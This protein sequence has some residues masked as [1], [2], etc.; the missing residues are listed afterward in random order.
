[1]LQTE[2]FPAS[3]GSARVTVTEATCQYFHSC[4]HVWAIWLELA[5]SRFKVSFNKFPQSNE[6]IILST[7]ADIWLT[8]S[9]PLLPC[10]CSDVTRL[11]LMI[12]KASSVLGTPCGKVSDCPCS[13]RTSPREQAAIKLRYAS[14]VS[15]LESRAA[16]FCGTLV[17]VP[18][19]TVPRH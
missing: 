1:M 9:P 10:T 11:P 3:N 14:G 19:P 6:Q 2:P 5:K 15:H 4:N 17:C 8:V 12:E 7:L 16:H 18:E 13:W